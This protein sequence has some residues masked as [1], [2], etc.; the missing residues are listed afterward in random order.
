M[1]MTLNFPLYVKVLAFLL[2][3]FITC[4][5]GWLSEHRPWL[6]R[7][8]G[9]LGIGLLASVLTS[10]GFCDPLF[11]RAEW[12]S[13]TGQEANRCQ[14]SIH[15]ED[16]QTFEHGGNVSQISVRDMEWGES[17]LSMDNPNRF[18]AYPDSGQYF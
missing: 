9:A 10:I 5:G 7:L 14:C 6:G 16:Y 11:W 12:R 8:L 17:I 4:W 13:L 18:S 3:I 2:A 1:P 15:G